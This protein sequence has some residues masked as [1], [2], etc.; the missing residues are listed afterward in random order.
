MIFDVPM[1]SDVFLGCL[2]RWIK[3]MAVITIVL[4]LGTVLPPMFVIAIVGSLEGVGMIV[5]MLP[6]DTH[7]AIVF[8][9][10][11]VHF[12]SMLEWP[13]DYLDKGSSAA[14]DFPWG[15][16]AK[17]SVDHLLYGAAVFAGAVA[18]F[19]IRDERSR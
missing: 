13:I 16:H 11:L 2:Q 12:I 7:N 14:T 3:G 10:G 19:S 4:S 1:A 15:A 8:S 9:Q 17:A 5:G 18:S 6:G